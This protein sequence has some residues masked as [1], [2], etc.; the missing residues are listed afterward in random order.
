MTAPLLEVED[1]TVR[2]GGA[3]VVD[4]VSLRLA[5]GETLALLGESGC[6]KSLTALA[7][8][9]LLPAAARITGGQ[10]RLEG[11]ELLRQPEMAM[12]RV[13]G[14]RIAM[15]FQEPM[16]ALNPVLD[17]E[18]QVGEAL[19]AHFGLGAAQRRERVRA[20][21][22]DVGIPDTARRLGEYP[23]QLSGGLKQRVMIAL[24]LAC[25]P[26]L[27]IADEPT[28]ALDVTLQA[29][30]LDLL[31]ELQ[32]RR[33]MALLFITHDLGVVARV[34]SR[35]AVMYAGQ[36]VEQAACG[37]FFTAPRHPYSQRLFASLPGL[38]RRGGSLPVLGGFVPGL[39]E[40]Q[41][42]PGCRFAPRCDQALPQ[43]AQTPPPW[44]E[45]AVGGMRC[46]LEIRGAGPRG[47]GEEAAMAAVGAADERKPGP[48]STQRIE[49]GA[50]LLE[51]DGL[52]VHFPIRQGVFR[53]ITGWVRAVDG[54]GLQLA[55][56]HTLALVGESGCGKTTLGKALLQLVVPTGGRVRFQSR[57]LTGLHGAA[58]RRER[59]GMQ[60]IFQDPSGSLNPRMTAGASI[61]EGLAEREPQARA[62]AVARLLVQV[63]LPA[64]AAA[65]YPHEFSGGQRQRLCIARALAAQPRLLVC[66]EPTSALDVSVQA[67]ILN[68]LQSLQQQLGLSY[69][70][71]SH[72]LPVVGWFAQEVAVMYLG[73][74]VERGPAAQLLRM[75]LHPYTRAL[76]AAAPVPDPAAQRPVLRLAGEPPSASAPPPGCHFHPRCPEARPECRQHYPAPRRMDGRSVTCHL[77]PEQQA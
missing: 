56:A 17:I 76:I 26:R 25:E 5:A 2:I 53:R 55:A 9:R 72:N 58:L 18:T 24:A 27:L 10:V 23:H 68:L 50:S 28:T 33:H 21:L 62:A 66:D 59:A 67:Q 20:L 73:R 22:A 12:Q 16:T 30:I 65:R 69:L 63:G 15:I 64:E 74:I 7:L 13:R 42:M 47:Q 38:E 44:R 45:D 11:E 77:Y 35:V 48:P 39:A 19:S 46:V 71:I 54:V 43:C 60:I 29:Q 1:L 41:A 40:L 32:Q 70:F 4:G 57:E 34:A 51:A 8:L 36:I 61:A 49:A 37:A 14:R 75:P 3:P 6:G 52:E 31:A